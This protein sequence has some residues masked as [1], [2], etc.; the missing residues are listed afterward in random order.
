MAI[1]LFE[2]NLRA[3]FFMSVKFFVSL[4]TVNVVNSGYQFYSEDTF[5]S[6]QLNGKVCTAQNPNVVITRVRSSIECAV[7]C[8]GTVGCK[9]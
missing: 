5:V 3:A 9:V 4:A 7:I 8:K 6:K 1:R 2:I